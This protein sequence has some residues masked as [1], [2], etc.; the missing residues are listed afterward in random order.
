LVINHPVGW[1]PD[2]PQPHLTPTVRTDPT[3]PSRALLVPLPVGQAGNDLHRALDHPLHLGQ[4]R[5]N[6]RLH[7]GKRLRRLHPV[8]P[9]ALE[10]LRHRV[11]H[12]PADK[13]LH[14][15]G[16]MFYP[17]RSVGAVM[18]RDPRAIIA[19]DAPD[20]DRRAHHVL[21]HVSRHAWIR[22]WDFALLPLPSLKKS[23]RHCTPHR[24]NALNTTAALW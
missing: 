21:G 10:A 3:V 22:R 23:S 18:I 24:S 11:L 5:L 19:I 17:L 14:S 4:G 20:G 7:L 2:T 13:R 1:M 15:D 12:H 16:F 9:D 6:R 8:I